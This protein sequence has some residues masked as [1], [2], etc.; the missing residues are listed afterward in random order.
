MLSSIRKAVRL[1]EM[2]SFFRELFEAGR[3]KTSQNLMDRK[4][5]VQV[6]DI[7][8]PVESIDVDY[9]GNVVLVI[10]ESE[11]PENE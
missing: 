10:D 3:F 11:I 7:N 1:V 8:C 5:Y 4:I 9:V 6:G 2:E